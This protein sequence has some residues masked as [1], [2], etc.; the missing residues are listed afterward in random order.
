MKEKQAMASFYAVLTAIQ[1]WCAAAWYRSD[2][3]GAD[4]AMV[5]TVGVAGVCLASCIRY[6]LS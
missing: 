4:V 6:L 1:L 3:V 2:V 5:V